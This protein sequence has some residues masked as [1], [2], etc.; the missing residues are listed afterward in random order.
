MTLI[1]CTTCLGQYAVNSAAGAAVV[2]CPQCGAPNRVPP[3]G[4][5]GAPP[6]L[7]DGPPNPVREYALLAGG[8]LVLVICIGVALKLRGGSGTPP[9]APPVTPPAREAADTP[10]ASTPEPQAP[11]TD[12]PAPTYAAA[13]AA[14]V[15]SDA[16]GKAC[17][18]ALRS[19]EPPAADLIALLQKNAPALNLFR[20]A[21]RLPTYDFRL[22]YEDGPDT[23]LDHLGYGRRLV[24]LLVLEARAACANGDW[25]TASESLAACFRFVRHLEG[26][27]LFAS[28]VQQSMIVNW[29]TAA[30]VGALERSLPPAD[31]C[32]RIAAACRDTRIRIADAVDHEFSAYEI[33]R[34]RIPTISLAPLLSTLGLEELRVALQRGKLSAHEAAELSTRLNL[35]AERL[36]RLQSEEDVRTLLQEGVEVARSLRDDFRAAF[37]LRGA[38]GIARM[39]ATEARLKQGPPLFR[40]L[41]EMAPGLRQTQQSANAR[42]AAC[43]VLAAVARHKR[44][45]GA[46]PAD[47]AAV[48]GCGGAPL[49]LDPDADQPFGYEIVGR[50]ISLRSTAR[51]A[52][53]PKPD[54]P[55]VVYV[56]LAN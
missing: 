52:Q 6:E 17:D 29:A 12:G 32:D 15:L 18:R 42:L 56:G 43:E 37:A 48:T 41:W 11:R 21:T 47:L 3:R 25:T 53:A 13:G 1:R 55:L 44:A 40:S 20:A 16:E 38:E 5:G 46:A 26:D 28:C 39:A 50:T 4:G 2:R 54:Q 7:P 36:Q 19:S 9:P 27:R 14:L 23:A 8:I 49:P 30:W 51:D 10:P 45:T 31:A 22:R 35:P 34:S 33:I 24:K